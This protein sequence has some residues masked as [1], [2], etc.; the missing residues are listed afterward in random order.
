MYMYKHRL[1]YIPFRLE[2]KEKLFLGVRLLLDRLLAR[3]NL[4]VRLLLYIKKKKEKDTCMPYKR[5]P[6]P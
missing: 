5:T 1:T 4:F 2:H 3:L 6:A